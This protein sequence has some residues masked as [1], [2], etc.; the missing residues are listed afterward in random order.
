MTP[1]DEIAIEFIWM[2]IGVM[3]ILFYLLNRGDD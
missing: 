1:F 2:L 3:L